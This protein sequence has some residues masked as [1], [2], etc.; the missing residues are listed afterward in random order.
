MTRIRKLSRFAKQDVDHAFAH[1]RRALRHP[2]ITILLAP[3][4]EGFGKI[5]VIASR[6]VGTAPE[7]NKL[8]RQLKAIF[9]E[10]KLYERGF[11]CILI[12]KKEITTRT[13]EQLKDLLRRAYEKASSWE[14][15]DSVSS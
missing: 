14:Q 13:F 7:R 3:Q 12:L 2:G 9:Y 1:A 6:K 4:R 5:L 15:A 8:R 11:D 10:E